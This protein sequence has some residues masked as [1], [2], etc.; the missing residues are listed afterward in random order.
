MLETA[1]ATPKP[2]AEIEMRAVATSPTIEVTLGAAAADAAAV[3]DV[4][5]PVL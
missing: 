4:G 1:D 3:A 5:A 2:T